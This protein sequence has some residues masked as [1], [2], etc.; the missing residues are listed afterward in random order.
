MRF[1]LAFKIILITCSQVSNQY[2]HIVHMI[3]GQRAIDYIRE[4]KRRR[5]NSIYIYLENFQ[6]QNFN[7]DIQ[8]EN[9][10]LNTLRGKYKTLSSDLSNEERQKAEIVINKI[11]VH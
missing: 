7:R 8:G 9:T 10:Y 3:N 1:M 11:E 6:I 4:K 2:L 5:R